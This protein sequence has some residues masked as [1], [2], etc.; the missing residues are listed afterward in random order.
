MLSAD[1]CL[2][3]LCYNTRMHDADVTI[4]DHFRRTRE[5]TVELF[6]R[7]P[8][9]LLAKQA[10]GEEHDL[11]W[12][13]AHM[14]DGVHW[15]MEHVMKDGSG[16]EGDLPTKRVTIQERLESS[17]NRLR[18]FFSNAD[19]ANMGKTFSFK[20]EDGTVTKWQGRDRV[21]YFAMHDLHHR[22][23]I[24]SMLHAWGFKDFP[25]YGW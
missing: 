23:K 12:Q 7:I 9:E 18:D 3:V 25:D 1:Y 21:L 2:L 5:L 14:T 4:L 16:F 24:Y 15:W 22:G 19:G 11:A 20:D 6:K 8:D 13:F 17:G 10:E